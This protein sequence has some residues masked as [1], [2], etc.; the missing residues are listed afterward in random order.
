MSVSWIINAP[1]PR[2][3]QRQLCGRP[4]C[5]RR[6]SRNTSHQRDQRSGLG[7]A[8]GCLQQR[9][10]APCLARTASY[11]YAPVMIKTKRDPFMP[12]IHATKGSRTT[13]CSATVINP[14]SPISASCMPYI[15]AVCVVLT[16]LQ[17]YSGG[18]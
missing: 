2:H 10:A 8:L 7:V 13:N 14:D 17:H 6:C 3:P 9:I 11:R 18:F 16:L 1:R 4:C 12:P 5:H 15:Y